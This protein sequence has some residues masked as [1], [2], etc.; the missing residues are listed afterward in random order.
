MLIAYAKSCWFLAIVSTSGHT[1]SR[2]IHKAP[3]NNAVRSAVVTVVVAGISLLACAIDPT[4]GIAGSGPVGSLGS[5][6]TCS[7]G[8]ADCSGDQGQWQKG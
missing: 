5:E 6:C 1:P 7:N 2:D 8:Q 4:D 3:M